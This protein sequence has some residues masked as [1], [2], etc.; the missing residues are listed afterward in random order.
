MSKRPSGSELLAWSLVGAG[1]GVVLGFVT[2][3]WL[4]GGRTS[5]A[6]S[7]SRASRGRPFSPISGPHAAIRAAYSVLEKDESLRTLGLEPVGVSRG[8]IEL[9]G[10]VPNRAL[11]A[12]AVRLVRAAP[13]IDRLID[14]LLV[15]G[16]DDAPNS[17]TDLTDQTA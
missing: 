1:L 3:E 4:G 16:E 17:A 7:P 11:R 15:H 8:V 6:P 5:A 12:R 2:G 10:W 9:H 14:C 13:D